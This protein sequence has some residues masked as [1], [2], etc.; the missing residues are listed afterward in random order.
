MLLLLV[1]LGPASLASEPFTITSSSTG[2]LLICGAAK[3]CAQALPAVRLSAEGLGARF[4]D[5]RVVIYENNSTDETAVLLN[6]W[7]ATNPKVKVRCEV[8]DE[9]SLQVMTTIR[10]RVSRPCRFEGIAWARNKMLEQARDPSFPPF[11]FIVM[12]DLDIPDVWPI[13]RLLYHVYRDDWD[14][15]TAFGID[16]YGFY[17]DYYALRDEQ[18]PLGPEFLGDRWFTVRRSSQYLPKRGQDLIP[19]RSAFG[20]LALYRSSAMLSF[21]F[22]A[23]VT[24]EMELEAQEL[25]QTR[26]EIVSLFE[27]FRGSNAPLTTLHSGWSPYPVTCEHESLFCSMRRSGFH[28]IFI[29]PQ[30]ILHRFGPPQRS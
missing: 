12:A 4:E 19:V 18:L 8:I 25:L 17:Y 20:G 6:E 30:M 3:N 7:A 2:T 11:D 28:R 26:S 1:A 16:Q 5:Y 23:T 21:S 13:D 22:S 24:P 29:D 9:A 10:D 27:Q 14:V 15:I